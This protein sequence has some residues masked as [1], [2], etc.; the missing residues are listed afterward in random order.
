MSNERLDPVGL[1]H[2]WVQRPLRSKR[3]FYMRMQRILGPVL[4]GCQNM[5]YQLPQPEGL[6][7]V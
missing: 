3:L 1:L 2:V 7:L 6:I 5:A 4:D